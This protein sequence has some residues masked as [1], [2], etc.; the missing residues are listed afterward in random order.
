MVSGSRGSGIVISWSVSISKGLRLPRYTCAGVH[1]V[2][3]PTSK[4]DGDNG[5]NIVANTA[6][7]AAA[8]A[9]ADADLA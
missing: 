9:D 5:S 8:A 3:S 4:C 2:S 7:A 6:A 1:F